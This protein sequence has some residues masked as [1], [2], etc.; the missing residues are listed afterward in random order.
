M[1]T[2][3]FHL[4]HGAIESPLDLRDWTL[5]SVGAPTAYPVSRFIDMSWTTASMQGQIG[6]CVACTGEE[7]VRRIIYLLTG[8]T[9]ELSF[10]FIYAVAKSLEGIVHP[11][12]GDFTKY[13]RTAGADDGTYPA[14]VA[15]IIRNIGVPLA[16]LCPNDV[17]LSVDDFCFQRNI[18][19]ISPVIF[20]DALTRK[21]G[22]DFTVPITEDGIKQA[23]N[24][25]ADNNGGVMILRYIGDTYWKDEFGNLTWD[26]ARLLPIRVPTIITGGHEEFP[27]GYEYEEGTNRLKIHWLNHWSKNWCN[28]GSA[29]EYF[30]VWAPN[31]KEIRVSVASIPTVAGFKYNFT[32]PLQ[33][34]SQ[35]PDVVALQ[36]VLKLEGCFPADLAFTGNF[37]SITAAGVTQLQQKYAAEILTPQGL[38][39][40][41]GYVGRG[42][43]AW[44]Q[45]HYGLNSN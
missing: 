42:T 7:V 29:W 35:G 17:T 27:T 26:P 24:Y 30:D 31:V 1:D 11:V 9:D 3:N 10:R 14:L 39:H 13:Y 41:T 4:G 44:L 37:Q 45:K 19:N 5:A 40:G 25:A 23:I 12:Y 20:T 36:H 18:A 21:S 8:R 6:C 15:W 32:V 43:L 16:S 38:I 34:G 28:N 33:R 22:A 2:T